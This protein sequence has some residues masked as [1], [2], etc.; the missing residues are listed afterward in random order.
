MLQLSLNGARLSK[1][2]FSWFKILDVKANSLSH[3]CGKKLF[4]FYMY[5]II[6]NKRKIEP[7]NAKLQTG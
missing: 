7:G 5:Q 6:Q 1:T 4:I 3:Y 2:S